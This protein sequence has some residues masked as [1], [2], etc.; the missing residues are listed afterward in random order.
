M[1]LQQ[2]LMNLVINGLDAM[3]DVD[4]NL[5]LASKS[6]RAE[7][8]ARR[9]GGCTPIGDEPR[10]VIGMNYGFPAPSQCILQR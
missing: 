2:V 6:Q 3:A 4:R 1:Q 8:R 7:N 10:L 5:E 9:G